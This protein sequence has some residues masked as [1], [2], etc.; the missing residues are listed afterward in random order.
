MRR[1]S[2]LLTLLL[3]AGCG[4]D[5]SS[6]LGPIVCPEAPAAI[7]P[8]DG[9]SCFTACGTRI[10]IG[11]AP[12][13]SGFG[14]LSAPVVRPFASNRV[15][16]GLVSLVPTGV[17]TRDGENGALKGELPLGG[18]PYAIAEAAG[19]AFVDTSAGVIYPVVV[20]DPEHPVVLASWRPEDTVRVVPVDN[21]RLILRTPDGVSLIDVTDPAAPVEANC[22]PIP[23][24]GGMDD[25]W[26]V[27][28]SA[29][30]V[31]AAGG[32]TT[33]RVYLFDLLRPDEIS[34]ALDIDAETSVILYKEI[35]V[36]TKDGGLIAYN[37]VPNASLSERGR[38]TLPAPVFEPPIIGGF[39]IYGAVA[40]DLDD[41]FAPYDVIDGGGA[42]CTVS[43]NAQDH[44]ASYFIAPGL[45]PDRRFALESLPEFECGPRETRFPNASAVAHEP[46]G[47]RLLITHDDGASVFDPTTNGRVDDVAIDGLPAWVGGALVGVRAAGTDF[48]M[49]L[50][51]ELSWASVDAPTTRAGDLSQPTAH[52]GHAADADALYLLVE[53]A[54]RDYGSDAPKPRTNQVL[55]FDPTT[56]ATTAVPLPS[57]AAPV[58]IAV[59]GGRLWYLDDGRQA[60]ALDAASPTFDEL[61][62]ADLDQGFGADAPHASALGLF[63]TDA[64]G[65][66]TWVDPA[67]AVAVFENETPGTL[68]GVDATRLYTLANDAPASTGL[69]GVR[70]L[71]A[72]APVGVSDGIATLNEAASLTVPD[73]G[74]A[75]APGTPLALVLG[76][77]HVL[78]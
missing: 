9:G 66:L 75:F 58:A 26:Q 11:D 25:V 50:T 32:S 51:T 52:L 24:E 43:L 63:F 35:L 57:K 38:V 10:A 33:P 13:S 67:G 53:G 7:D 23:A 64:C 54:G 6:V 78:E 29:G 62:R 20:N 42:A 61:A 30:F 14:V 28:A 65:A 56:G 68:L 74:A 37:A 15:G 27:T 4:G 76:G 36:I 44:S 55:R 39:A 12:L 17:Q 77:L 45:I 2:L 3:V 22:L 49:P 59:S 69:P 71:V 70:R 41:A 21:R 1:A 60:V 16:Q 48:N 18:S 31:A 72:W 47:S 73:G 46:A 5:T 19:L 8:C 34:A 40:L